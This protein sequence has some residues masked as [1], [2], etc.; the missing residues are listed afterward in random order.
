MGKI[1]ISQSVEALD[2]GCKYDVRIQR[3]CR[4][5]RI[6]TI[7]ELCQSTEKGLGRIYDLGSGSIEKIKSVLGAYGLRPG[8]SNEELDTYTG[9]EQNKR[10]IPDA[11]SC[12]AD[13]DDRIW[14]QRR[15]EIA[16]AMFVQ[17]RLH[18]VAAVREADGLICALR[19]IQYP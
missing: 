6:N 8:M 18:P 13:T 4:D 17:H 2:F 19:D 9:I 7:R 5:Y 14:E 12:Q 10:D 1:D 16:K 15:Y 3:I 11:P